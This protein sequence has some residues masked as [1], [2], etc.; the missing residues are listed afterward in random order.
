MPEYL[1]PGVYVE[2]V[3]AGPKPI[4]GVSTST[5]GAVGVTALGPDTGKPVLITS[6][7]E[8]M[9]KFGGS[10]V[11]DEATM[12]RWSGDPQRGEFWTFP[13][14]IKGFFDNGGQRIYVRR[15]VASAAS[16]A[17]VSLGRGLMA[18]VAADTVEQA[19]TIQ[20][21]SL[22]GIHKGVDVRIRA[23]GT[24]LPANRVIG[25]DPAARMITLATPVGPRLKAGSDHVQISTVKDASLKVKAKSVGTWGQYLSVRGSPM[26]AGAYQLL[27]AP[28]GDQPNEP[29]QTRIDRDVEVDDTFVVADPRNLTR[30]DRIAVGGATYRIAAVDGNKIT[31]E[32]VPLE[33]PGPFARKWKA[34]PATVDGAPGPGAKIKDSGAAETDTFEVDDAKKLKAPDG[35]A[36]GDV[37][38]VENEKFR[39]T[40]VDTNKITVQPV[41]RP[42]P[43]PEALR[44]A[45]GATVKLKDS[46]AAGTTIQGDSTGDTFEVADAK[47]LNDPQALPKKDDIVIVDGRPYRITAV[48]TNKITVK[49]GRSWTRGA[50]VLRTRY[51]ARTVGVAPEL[52][53]WGAAALYK[54][55][56]VEIESWVTGR[57]YYGTIS[58]DVNGNKIKLAL[59]NYGA[60]DLGFD[61][62][63]GDRL[64]LIE[65]VFDVR[66]S[67]PDSSSRSE[68]IRNVRL[69]GDRHDPL[70]IENRL[71]A[72][73]GLIDYIKVAGDVADTGLTSL[74]S[75]PLAVDNPNNAEPQAQL[76][77][78]LAG[79]DDNFGSLEVDAFVGRDG[80]PGK[81][82]GIQALE[83]IDDISICMVPSIWSSLVQNALIQHCELLKYRFAILDP[84]P[85]NPSSID[86]IGDIRA[87]REGF[88]SKYAALYFPRI[89]VRDPFSPRTVGLGPSGHMAGIYA[90]VD[91]ERGVHKAPANEVIRGLD[92]A[93]EFH[94]LEDEI[95]KREQDML[96]PKGINALRFF[97][98]RGTRVWGARTLSSDGAWRYINVRR[99]F[100]YVERS[101]D[102]GTQWVVFEPND[103]GTWARVR[104]T[105]SNFLDSVWR[106]GALFGTKAEE[107]FF[108][109]CDRTT[110]TQDDIDNGRLIVV[111][112]IAPVKPAEFV[113]FR[114]Q[115]KLIDQKQP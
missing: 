53:V 105:I 1:S 42:E 19:R 51:A 77:A 58:D 47:T 112:G 49:R 113:I 48:D 90:R 91:N 11:L 59:N 67:P 61:L 108:V 103:E 44:W 28:A 102:V 5:A 110:M 26:D 54:G 46:K 81:R 70:H 76:W 7:A 22:I 87:F 31:V 100:I 21:D 85:V 94:G 18:A 71:S 34:G 111:I 39:I 2:E 57:K 36:A 16:A 24:L 83:D 75:F 109:R 45:K 79:G 74:A 72:A 92:T 12:A 30:G 66:Y 41:V 32:L 8:Y 88:D 114:V 43:R 106:S 3:D 63:E 101:I 68:V 55:A 99:I 97:P 35:P 78:P 93:N 96:N 98:D 15:V 104:Q 13:L 64:H 107:A 38:T 73:S 6:F 10:V 23:S 14:A 69:G 27:A 62:W 17:E 80:G 115:Q 33:A 4:E 86:P 89:E 60:A 52:H 29:T 37:V 50:T 84:M 20:V 95:S 82:T 65:A 9:N 40:A 25:V 56:L